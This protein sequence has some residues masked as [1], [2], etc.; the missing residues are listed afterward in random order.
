MTVSAVL[1]FHSHLPA[2]ALANLS[3][4]IHATQFLPDIIIAL[5]AMLKRQEGL[6]VGKELPSLSY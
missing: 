2:A 3:H 5:W 6:T 1:T 4:S